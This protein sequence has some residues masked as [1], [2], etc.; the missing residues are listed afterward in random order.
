M[1]S[2][3]NCR[4]Y[5]RYLLFISLA[6]PLVGLDTTANA[7]DRPTFAVASVRIHPNDSNPHVTSMQDGADGVNYSG[8]GIKPC[9]LSAYGIKASQLEG[10][11]GHQLERYDIVAKA[12]HQVPRKE[13]MAMLQVLLEERFKLKFHFT[14]KVAPAYQLAAGTG[15]LRPPTAADGDAGSEMSPG[16]FAANRTS[17]QRLADL[18][19]GFADLPVMVDPA[20][21]PEAFALNLTW[22]M[23]EGREQAMDTLFDAV[24]RQTGFRI[25]RTSL[26]VRTMVIDHIN[27]IPTDN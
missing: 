6:A 4:G 12:D 15:K 23:G 10:L 13:L 20:G 14:T 21:M 11:D 7:Q 22:T 19:S 3:K 25:E 17:P 8:A 9:I 1:A 27:S 2:A 26:N 24:R 5:E 16:R 18:L